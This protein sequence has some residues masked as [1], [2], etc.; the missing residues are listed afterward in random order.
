[1]SRR[2]PVNTPQPQPAAAARS[3]DGPPAD[4][5]SVRIGARR[6]PLAEFLHR[7]ASPDLGHSGGGADPDLVAARDAFLGAGLSALRLATAGTTWV[8]YGLEPGAQ[9][10]GRLCAEL[11]GTARELLR[12]E[13]ADGFFFMF[14]PPGLRVRFATAGPNRSRLDALLQ[15]RLRSW[16]RRGLVAAWCRGVYEAES[17]LFGGPASMRRVHRL[18]AADSSAWLGY[19]RAALDPAGT[20]RPG[21]AWAMSLAMVHA[22]FD[23]LEIVGW[24]DL[25]VWDRVRRQTGR[26][27][28]PGAVGDEGFVRLAQ[29]LRRGWEDPDALRALLSPGARALVE[30]YRRSVARQGA[31]WREEYVGTPQ[32]A[33]GPREA[34]AYLI[35]FHWNRGRFPLARQALITEALAARSTAE[36]P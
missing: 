21:P 3:C 16:E 5:V 20:D 9:H 14:K 23:A 24:E 31:L 34:A 33:V 27:L 8:Q 6:L 2:P 25:D 12:E 35:V 19:H 22:L 1:M 13:T 29:A 7:C 36:Q 10:L 30:E 4:G 17:Y 11:D 28:A 18:F 32:A 15:E 26:R